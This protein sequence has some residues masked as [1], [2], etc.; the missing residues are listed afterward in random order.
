MVGLR[1]IGTT[2]GVI[3]AMTSNSLRRLPLMREPW[4]HVGL[5]FGGF[6]VGGYLDGVNKRTQ[7]DV[8]EMLALQ[9]RKTQQARAQEKLEQ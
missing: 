4:W 8:E 2:G 3:A 9:G 1:L 7:K 6:V 5:A